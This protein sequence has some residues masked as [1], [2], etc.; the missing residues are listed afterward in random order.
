[1]KAPLHRNSAFKL[2]EQPLLPHMREPLTIF[3]NMSFLRVFWQMLGWPV[4]PSEAGLA[5]ASAWLL[6]L[7]QFS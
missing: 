7:T 4:S 1:M 3:K 5:T 6:V 2:A